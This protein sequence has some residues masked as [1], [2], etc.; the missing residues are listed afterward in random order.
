LIVRLQYH[1]PTIPKNQKSKTH[2]EH[3]KKKK[4]KRRLLGAVSAAVM[5]DGAQNSKATTATLSAEL[6]GS[7]V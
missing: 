5:Q 2:I 1:K 6:S 3:T 4:E 7:S